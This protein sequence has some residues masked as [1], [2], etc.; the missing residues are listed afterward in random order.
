MILQNSKNF[1]NKAGSLPA[2]TDEERLLISRAAELSARC[3]YSAVASCF[4]SPREQRILFESGAAAG[5][6]FYG[7][8]LGATR[9]KLVF[10]PGWIECDN[11]ACNNAFS[12]EKE[13]QLEEL[14]SSYGCEDMMSEFYVPLHLKCSGYEKLSHRD[15]LGSLMALG[16]KRETVGDICF[17]EGKAYVF[18]EPKAA[19][20]IENELKRA[21]RAKVSAE[22]CS[23]PEDF[24]IELNYENVST[25]VASPRI[26]GVVRAL[27]NMSRDDAAQLVE[28][29]F[30][31]LNYFTETEVDAKISGGD[32]ISVR[33]HGKYI[34]DSADEQTK[35]G[36]VRIAARK[37][38]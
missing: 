38:V 23:L 35:K 22:I 3:D 7:G 20:Y 8:A 2:L 12:P 25:T 1:I 29:G 4:L 21:G 19:A 6:F 17:F 11:S 31:E 26:D 32:I 33:G 18:A 24:R 14:L 34:V 10:L 30:V 9:R 5:G 28:S 16:I 27:C 37:L 36:R 13:L 15:W